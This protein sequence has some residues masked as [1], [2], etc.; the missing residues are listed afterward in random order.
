ME[1]WKMKKTFSK[2]GK[3][4]EL[5]KS[6]KNLEKSCNLEKSTWKKSWNFVSDLKFYESNLLH[7]FVHF[8]VVQ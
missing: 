3:I 4:M 8:T 5:G 7:D 6:P 2:P 1:T